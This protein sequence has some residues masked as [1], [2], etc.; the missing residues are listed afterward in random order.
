MVMPGSPDA[1]FIQ[2]GELSSR[3]TYHCFPIISRLWVRIAADFSLTLYR[4]A[5]LISSNMQ[6]TTEG[7][8]KIIIVIVIVIVIFTLIT[9]PIK[10]KETSLLFASQT[11]VA[12]LVELRVVTREVVSLTPTGPTLRVLN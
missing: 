5:K 6:V 10:T 3:E 9:A 1:T 11:P 12:P 7:R 8:E 2:R 4:A